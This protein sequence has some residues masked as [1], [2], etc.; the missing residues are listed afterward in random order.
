MA[1]TTAEQTELDSLTAALL[2]LRTG[3]MPS[4]VVYQGRETNFAK[5]DL[6]DLKAR[7]FQLT[8]KANC[9]SGRRGGPFAGAYRYTVR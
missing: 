9:G 3:Q 2:Q 1:L 5:V 4:R 7:V 6:N 8:R